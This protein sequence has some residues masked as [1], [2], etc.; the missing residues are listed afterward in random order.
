M[1]SRW[2]LVLVV[3]LPVT[4]IFQ[5]TTLTV[6]AEEKGDSVEGEDSNVDE[7]PRLGEGA[8]TG[9]DAEDDDPSRV[10]AHPDADVHFLFTKPSQTGLGNELPAGKD[11]SF[12]VGFAN[13]GQKDLIIDT[14]EASIR[15]AQDFSY[16]LQ[17]FTAIGYNKVVRPREEATLA[18]GFFVSDQ[19]SARAY[20]LTV[21][22][23]YRDAEG[24]QYVNAAFNETVNIIELDEGLD[25]E[26]FFLYIVLIGFVVLIVVGI[27]QLLSS[28]TGKSSS[29]FSKPKVEM[30]TNNSNDVDY[31]WLPESTLNILNKSPKGGKQS[32]RQRRAAKRST[33]AD[34]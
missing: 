18:Y 31:D 20:G 27:Q 7:E 5:G 16:H 33:G 34:D 12:L 19:Y 32:P 8:L 9:Q 26:T 14:M 4:L 23:Y 2:M 15:Y 6:A 3:L 29:S 22:L 10:K 24:N 28:Y 25:T 1:F 17:N 13:T 30:G 21:N 11:V